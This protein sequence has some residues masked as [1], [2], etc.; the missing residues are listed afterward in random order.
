MWLKYFIYFQKGNHR[1]R[2]KLKNSN[3]FI[4]KFESPSIGGFS[5][6]LVS[7]LRL[8]SLYILQEVH[9]QS[10]NYYFYL[11][12]D[13]LR[14]LFYNLP[15]VKPDSLSRHVRTIWFFLMTSQFSLLKLLRL[16]PISLS[17]RWYISH[18]NNLGRPNRAWTSGADAA[19][20][21][22]LLEYP[23]SRWY[24]G[25]RQRTDV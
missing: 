5:Q 11:N 6:F 18:P 13:I 1:N 21:Q 16:F 22:I 19:F 2:I 17:W 23:T 14:M 15:F 4:V 10:S 25:N 20:L 7:L 3:R 9:I 8:N 12:D 24:K